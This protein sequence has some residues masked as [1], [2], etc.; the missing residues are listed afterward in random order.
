MMYATGTAAPAVAAAA[1]NQAAATQ[2]RDLSRLFNEIW[3]D[4]LKHSPE[5]ATYLG[6]KR[7]DTELT[8]YSPRAVN[9]ALARG[10]GYIERL[11]AID[12]TGL[13]VSREQMEELLRVD[14]EGWRAEVPLIQEY[15][16]KFGD[17]LP[18]ALADQAETLGRRLG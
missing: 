7:Y 12:T 3:Q 16:A 6:D 1:Q 2:S 10:R 11:S 9:E 5:Y 8:D 17:R 14:T 13:D 15:Y 4:K 18:Q